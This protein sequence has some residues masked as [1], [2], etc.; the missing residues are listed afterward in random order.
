MK[1]KELKLDKYAKNTI[2]N[3]ISRYYASFLSSSKN[4]VNRNSKKSTL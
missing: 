1:P 3:I 4:K 2:I